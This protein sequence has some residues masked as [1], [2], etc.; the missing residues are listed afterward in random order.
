MTAMSRNASLAPESL[1]RNPVQSM[2]IQ[3]KLSKYS[4]LTSNSAVLEC[5]GFKSTSLYLS[6]IIEIV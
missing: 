3:D 6:S 1:Q 2:R 4:E 5:N